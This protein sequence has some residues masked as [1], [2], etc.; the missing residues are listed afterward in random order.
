MNGYH[1]TI[2]WND[3]CTKVLK[4]ITYAANYVSL[5][6]MTLQKEMKEL[7]GMNY[8]DC[9]SGK[10]MRQQIECFFV[11]S[12]HDDDDSARSTSSLQCVE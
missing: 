11:G 2:S 10:E 9:F 6:E 7:L 5:D 3:Q 12:T 4:K 8:D 1:Q